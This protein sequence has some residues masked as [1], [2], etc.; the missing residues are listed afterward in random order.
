MITEC[1]ESSR[2][3]EVV[4]HTRAQIVRQPPDFLDGAVQRLD[5]AVD[6]DSRI[7]DIGPDLAAGKVHRIAHADEILGN[8]V[9]QLAG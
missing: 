5:T 8:A 9:V 4:E 6:G 1:L 3:A 7:V 2:Q